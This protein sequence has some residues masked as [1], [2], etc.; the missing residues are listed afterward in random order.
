MRVTAILSSKKPGSVAPFVGNACLIEKFL[1]RCAELYF[2]LVF[3]NVELELVRPSLLANQRYNRLLI[4]W[5]K[6]CSSLFLCQNISRLIQES[7]ALVSSKKSP[8]ETS[9]SPS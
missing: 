3:G 5:Q 4:R 1:R 9:E 2:H 6:N 8:T 7:E